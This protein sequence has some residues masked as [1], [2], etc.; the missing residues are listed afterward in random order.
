MK[1]FEWFEWFE[2]FGPSPIEPFNSGLRCCDTGGMREDAEY[3]QRILGMCMT[4]AYTP[5]VWRNFSAY[6]LDASKE[7]GRAVGCAARLAGTAL[8]FYGG[9]GGSASVLVESLENCAQEV[10]HPLPP[11]LKRQS[12][13]LRHTYLWQK[14]SWLLIFVGC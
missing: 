13:L 11:S 9:E 3:V 2:W 4:G 7:I 8:D 12:I 1:E 5:R 10:L 6:A 14:N